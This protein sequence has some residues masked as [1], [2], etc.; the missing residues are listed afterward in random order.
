MYLNLG[1]IDIGV[2]D[3]K[4]LSIFTALHLFKRINVNYY[5][6]NFCV[7]RKFHCVIYLQVF[8]A[9]TAELLSHHQVEIKQEFPREG[10]DFFFI[11]SFV[12]ILVELMC[13]YL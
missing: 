5:C 1:Y 3:R 10:Y 8:N 7:H 12:Y 13:F 11:F 2:D 6:L 9:K 4:L